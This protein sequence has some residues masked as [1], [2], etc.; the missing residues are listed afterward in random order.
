MLGISK[1]R[2]LSIDGHPEIT[3]TKGRSNRGKSILLFIKIASGQFEILKMIMR[4]TS[5][6]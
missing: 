4:F 1:T 3:K 2:S 6:I 5:I